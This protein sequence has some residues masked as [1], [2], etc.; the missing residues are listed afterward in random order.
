MDSHNSPQNA[1]AAIR[2][3]SVKQGLQGDSPEDQKQQIDR[4]A[5]ARNITVKK[6]FVFME[7][8]SKDEQPVQ[9]AIN[10]CMDEKNDIQCFIIK[11][12]DRF[13]RGGSYLYDH[14]KRQL[15]LADVQLLDIYGIISNTNINTLEHLGVEY[16]WS[17]YSP[18]KKAEI[19]E[20]ERAK[21]EMRDIMTRMIGAEIRYVRM[22]YRVRRAPYG[23]M[24]QKVETEHGKRVILVP[25]PEESVWIKRM[26]DLK[27]RGTLNDPQIV[28]ELNKLGFRT[29]TIHKRD[30]NNRTKIIGERGNKPITIKQFWRYIRNPIYAGVNVEKWTNYKPVRGNFEGIVSI[31]EFNQANRTKVALVEVD[32]ELKLIKGK[33]PSHLAKKLHKNPKFPYRKYIL[34]PECNKPLSGSAS[35]GRNGTYY[36]SYH[37]ARKGHY[38]R[39]PKGEFMKQ[40]KK[41]VGKL[42]ITPEYVEDLCQAVLEVWDH[43]QKDLHAESDQLDKKISELKNHTISLVEK[44]KLLSSATAIS[45]IEKELEETEE[46][47]AAFELEKQNKSKKQ[48]DIERV[49]EKA[50]YYM[51]H[52]DELIFKGKDQLKNAE[53]FKL[54]FSKPPTYEEIILR[55]ARLSQYI[56][57]KSKYEDN[58]GQLVTPAGFEPAIFRMRT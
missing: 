32:G 51:N 21:D 17:K 58:K 37:C 48:I 10:Y 33:V 35:R 53:Y 30:P 29:R 1:V 18:T 36:P 13:T 56:A 25:G 26:Y 4:Y 9:E 45:Y 22:G 39:V 34:C 12:I 28:D 31:E 50:R 8:A 55:N 52:M 44:I 2:I 5:Q 20:A 3:S 46:K 40:L 42:D 47:I 7:S 16:T 24:N 11:S 49:L 14:L 15:E 41:F 54:I 19:L 6:Y 38:F 23:Y 27:L 57:L 43:R